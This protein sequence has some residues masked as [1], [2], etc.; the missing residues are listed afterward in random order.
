MLAL[1]RQSGVPLV[2]QLVR[3]L[4]FD[5]ATGRY[6]VGDVLPS[7]RT[8]A[9]RLEIS[10]H[11]VRK[12]YQALAEL[13]LVESR[14][15]SGYLVKQTAGETR[16]ERLE[17]GATVAQDAVQRL[18]GIGLNDLEVEMV[19]ME[20]LAQLEQ[21]KGIPEILFAA[22]YLELAQ[23]CSELVEQAIYLPVEPV[24]I[25]DLTRHPEAEYVITPFATLQTVL[26]EAPESHGIGV[27]V[28]YS[29]ELQESLAHLMPH[30]TVGIA[31]LDPT[32]VEP[33]MIDIRRQTGFAG[34]VFGLSAHADTAEFKNLLAQVDLLLYTHQ[35]RRRV[36]SRLAGHPSVELDPRVAVESLDALRRTFA[37]R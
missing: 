29:H 2:A 7:T 22:P 3:Q 37:S 36:R 10:F 20:Q 16:S 24:V 30:N 26:Q 12:A 25:T 13:G 9:R 19:L 28:F 33:I 31:A 8:L 1:D 32:S 17:A 14:G 27:T 11:T 15:G 34:Q 4:R 35:S 18:I 6:Q 23:R 5:I 21:A